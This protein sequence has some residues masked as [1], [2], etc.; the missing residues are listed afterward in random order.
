MGNPKFWNFVHYVWLGYPI[1]LVS[2]ESRENIWL[3]HVSRNI[4]YVVHGSRNQKF[5][6]HGK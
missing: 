2:H 4:R 5:T 3:F 1:P 6:D